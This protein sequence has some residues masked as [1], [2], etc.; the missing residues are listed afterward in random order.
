MDL[1]NLFWEPGVEDIQNSRNFFSVELV[2]NEVLLTQYPQLSGKLGS[3]TVDLAQYVHDDAIDTADKSAVVDWYYKK[4]GLL[5]YCKYCNDEVLFATENDP[6]YAQRGWYDHGLYP[7]HFDPLFRLP[8][9]PCGFGYIDIGKNEQ[10]YIDRGGKAI[11][12][13]VLANARPRHFIRAD[14]SVNEEEYA[15]MTRDFVHVDGNLGQDSIIPIQTNP[16]N[17]I[18]CQVI[19]DK[20]NEIKEVTGNRDIATGGTTAGVTAASAIAAMQEAG[21]KLSRDNN[22]AS[23]RVFKSVCLMVIE[24]IRQFYDQP[25]TFRILG[26]QGTAEY[27]MFSNA[28]MVPQPQGMEMGIDMGTRIPL[29]DINVVPQKAS[30]YS[31][32]AQNELALQ[33]YG[34]GF[35]NPMMA[36]QAL[37]CLQM[38]D[39]DGKDKLIRSIQQNQMMMM[40]VNPLAAGAMGQPGEAPQ[41]G[42]DGGESSVTANARKRVADSTAPR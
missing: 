25:R 31:K 6:Q 3:S 8:G 13:N 35:F 42:I 16:L 1:V 27:I 20:V 11:M 33:F 9:T 24:L 18:Y 26:E 22:K 19:N 2:G 21:S 30:P 23:Y 28:G 17:A 14:G 15:D 38:M 41:G 12:Q 5:H 37:A 4:N 39:F 36:P 7:F 40:M 34:A 32:M 10:E 29:F